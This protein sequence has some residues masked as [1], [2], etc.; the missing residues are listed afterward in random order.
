MNAV[1]EAIDHYN[2]T[3]SIDTSQIDFVTQ[4]S[5]SGICKEFYLRG[6]GEVK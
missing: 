1:P 5:A 2:N 6:G 4:V 3:Y